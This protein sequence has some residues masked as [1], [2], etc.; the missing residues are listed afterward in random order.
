MA[1]RRQPRDDPGMIVNDCMSRAPQRVRVTDRLDAAARVMWDHDCGFVPVLDG[2][3]RLVGVVTDRDLCM[4]AFT[5]G[6]PLHELPMAAAMARQV[7]TV[8][9]DDS[10]ATAMAAMQEVAVRRLP[11]VDAEGRLVG[12]LSSNDLVRHAHAGHREVAAEHD[13]EAPGLQGGE[14]ARLH[15]AAE[16]RHLVF[17]G[18][19]HAAHDGA[20]HALVEGQHALLLHVG[21]GRLHRGMAHGLVG[22]PLPVVQAA[23]EALHLNVRSHAEDARAQFFLKAVH[24]R[25]HHDQRRDAKRDA[26]HR[27]QRNEGN[28]AVAPL[29]PLARARVA[30]ADEKFVEHRKRFGR[31]VQQARHCA[32][33]EAIVTS[34]IDVRL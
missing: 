25:Q 14:V 20:A 22:H 11:V 15:V 4:A 8:R 9:A 5:Q 26:E 17:F 24:H 34:P 19:D 12:V 33:A 32:R 31:S 28:E 16:I 1:R 10:L 2:A 6:R 30:Q 21:R 7:R 18:R 27:H 23:V 29:C 3:D 13:A